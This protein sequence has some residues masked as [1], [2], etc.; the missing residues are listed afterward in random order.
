MTLWAAIDQK[1]RNK[2]ILARNLQSDKMPPDHERCTRANSG[3]RDLGT[4]LTEGLKPPKYVG[5][6]FII[7]KRFCDE[8]IVLA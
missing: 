4:G 2:I 5:V 3:Y 7:L 1:A 6:T 8:K